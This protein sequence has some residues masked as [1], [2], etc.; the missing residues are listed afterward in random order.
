MRV[1][2]RI[3]SLVHGAALAGILAGVLGSAGML[4]AV[5]QET[6]KK[7]IASAADL[8]RFTYPVDGPAS[9]LLTADAATFAAFA[10]KM[11]ANIDTL[12]AQYDIQDRGTLRGI[13][14]EKLQ[15]Q[16][17]SGTEDAA[18]LQTIA[19]IR[20]LEDKPDSKLLSGLLSTALIGARADAG[21]A[22]GDAFGA[23]LA[24]RYAAAIA[25]LPWSVV[26]T[27]FKEAKTQYD[28]LTP[29]LMTG[30]IAAAV[31]PG[32]AKTHELSGDTAALIL[33]TRYY[34]ALLY[35]A[36][37]QLSAVL[38]TVIAKNSVVKPDIWAAREVTLHASD[39]L[40]PV[41]LA[42]WDS[43]SDV[44]LFGSRVFTDPHP[45]STD[46]HGLAF[47]LLGFPAH[48]YLLPLDAAQ[49][50]MFPGKVAFLEGFSDLSEGIDSPA[51][52]D[53]KKQMTTMAQADVAN[54]FQ[55][56]ELA[57]IYSHGTHVAG[58][59]MR[60][61]P[62]AQLVVARITFDYKTIPTPPTEET[63]RRNARDYQTYVDYF[64]AHNVR[65]VNMS[66]GGTPAD[67]EAV[68]EK[69]G[70]GKDANERKALAAKYF[71]IDRD[72][73]YKALKSAP[74]I[75]FVCAAGNSNADA[76]FNEDI[77]AGFDL[78]NLLVVGA[79]DQAGD[80][81]SFTSYGKTVKVD[82]DGYHVLSYVPGGTQVKLS[83][84]SMASP[85]VA[86]LAGKLIALDPKLTPAQT[87]ALIRAGATPTADGRRFNI[88]PKASVALLRKQLAKH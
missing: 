15:L 73:L 72:G 61:N 10:A 53:V 81:T 39:R 31:D 4:P 51:A 23:A 27:A 83:G 84:T 41:R 8:P 47:D 29:A 25:P 48:G 22:T 24:K 57:S 66:W 14:G 79:V 76:G 12:L 46:P 6:A 45:G 16:L 40:T 58:I 50:A 30:Q 32:V 67:D 80:E 78:P 18:A 88:N 75:L 9:A 54:F 34:L 60:G 35:P 5:A 21:S 52:T 77:P 44:K 49:R 28:V 70:I 38:A 55:D 26:G 64:R 59:A 87:I 2:V 33:R 62:A 13:L 86:N 68:L 19:Q 85:N 20:T 7:P 65:V 43:G 82:A 36:H 37:A 3:A 63:E 42:V 74:G 17:L 69:N 56:L 1:K 11:R 71:A